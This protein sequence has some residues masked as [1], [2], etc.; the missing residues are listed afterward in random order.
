MRDF[1]IIHQGR[2]KSRYTCPV[3]L[4]KKMDNQICSANQVRHW[5]I[6]NSIGKYRFHQA[7]DNG[8]Q[9]RLAGT[10]LLLS[11]SLREQSHQWQTRMSVLP[12]MCMIRL[13]RSFRLWTYA[14]H[15]KNF[16]FCRIPGISA[17]PR[18]RRVCKHTLLNKCGDYASSKIQ[19][20]RGNLVESKLNTP[21]V[22]AR[23]CNDRRNLM[24]SIDDPQTHF[25]FSITTSGCSF[26]P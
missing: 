14:S 4:C 20:L 15:K 5:R 21:G 2:K 22:I 3:S 11:T 9:M 26:K 13:F 23:E 24:G 10:K 7:N 17:S 6:G 8:I 1:Q 16:V 25:R 12:I 18:F 19:R